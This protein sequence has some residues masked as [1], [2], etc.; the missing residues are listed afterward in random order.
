MTRFIGI[1]NLAESDYFLSQEKQHHDD[2]T[3]NRT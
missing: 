2:H 3:T 1:G